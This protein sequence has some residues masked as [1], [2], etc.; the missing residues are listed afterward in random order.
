MVN[1]N[2]RRG[3]KWERDVADFWA[4]VFPDADRRVKGG[5][6][7]R[8]DLAGV[9]GVCGEMK[10]EAKHS[11]GTYMDEVKVEQANARATWGWCFLKRRGF[12]VKHGYAICT[13]EQAR[14]IHKLLADQLRMRRDMVDD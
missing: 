7:D 6:K 9:P 5:P 3:A 10:D 1:P 11:L 12:N 14:A 13:I 2:G 4:E 8:G